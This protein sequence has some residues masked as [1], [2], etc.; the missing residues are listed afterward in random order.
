MVATEVDDAETTEL[1]ELT[2]RGAWRLLCIKTMMQAVEDYCQSTNLFARLRKARELGVD[3]SR[4]PIDDRWLQGGQGAVTFED[5]CEVMGVRPS[6]AREKIE[7]Y[8]F[9]RRRDRPANV[10]W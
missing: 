7:E 5:C 2:M 9:S 6:V 4:L 3:P 1:D 8:A 10:N